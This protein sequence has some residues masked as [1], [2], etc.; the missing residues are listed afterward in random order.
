M[1][2]L[3][4]LSIDFDF[5]QNVKKVKTL[6][7]CYPDGVDLPSQITAI[8]WASRYLCFEKE[9]LEITADTA[10]IKE[11]TEIVRKNCNVQTPVMV[12]NSHVHIYEFIKDLIDTNEPDSTYIV[13]IDMHHDTVNGNKELDCGNWISH[14]KKDFDNCEVQ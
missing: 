11:I 13:N 14:V 3:N 5:F 7:H 10:K 1:K 9:L 2:E 12:T 8:T 6:L 4:I